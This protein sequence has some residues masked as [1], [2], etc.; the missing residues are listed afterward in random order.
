MPLIMLLA[1]SADS[2]ADFRATKA[3]DTVVE[4]RA[5]TIQGSYGQA[6]NGK[7]FQQDAVVTHNEYQYVA[8]Y[9]ATRQV[10]LARRKLPAGTWDVLRFGDYKFKSS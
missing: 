3:D 6:I 2:L 9:D 4:T 8:Y 5:L 7:A 10:S 1:I